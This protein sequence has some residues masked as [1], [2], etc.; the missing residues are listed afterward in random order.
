MVL[1][2][3]LGMNKNQG[4]YVNLENT[5]FWECFQRTSDIGMWLQAF[6]ILVH[7]SENS[8]FK[9]D[10]NDQKTAC[11]MLFHFSRTSE[12]GNSGGWS[13]HK[14]KELS[15]G[16]INK[17]LSQV[18]FIVKK[19]YWE[20]EQSWE[21]ELMKR[22]QCSVKQYRWG[23]AQ[24]RKRRHQHQSEAFRRGGLLKNRKHNFSETL[25]TELSY[26]L[27]LGVCPTDLKVEAQTGYSCVHSSIVHRNHDGGET[28]K[29]KGA[30]GGNA[31]TH[32]RDF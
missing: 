18:P 30:H 20:E 21:S 9:E 11:S 16:K 8:N 14:E 13:I 12:G 15:A 22:A 17:C 7:C 25:N 3:G 4:T 10:L 31:C 23:E 26:D 29:A 19:R 24:T 28:A 6:F 27:L 5:S 32:N 2:I 1:K